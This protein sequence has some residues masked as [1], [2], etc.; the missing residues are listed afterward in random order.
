MK[1]NLL[2]TRFLREND[3]LETDEAL[4]ICQGLY[5]FVTGIWPLIDIVSF[6]KVT[7][8]KTDLWLVKTVGS[9]IA[10]I[11]L[12]LFIA[13]WSGDFGFEIV[14]L[15]VGSSLALTLVDF[16]Y[17]G[18]GTISRIYLLDAVIEIVIISLWVLARMSSS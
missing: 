16:V 8:P 2:L 6:Q 17:V 7:G 15:A 14:V 4:A 3:R 5:F 13:G 18:N 10:V 9:L 11:G 12:V 1:I